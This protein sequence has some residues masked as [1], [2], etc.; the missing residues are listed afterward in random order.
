MMPR[1]LET[2]LFAKLI[3]ITL[4]N[5]FKNKKTTTNI[6]FPM[7]PI[8]YTIAREVNQKLLDGIPRNIVHTIYKLVTRSCI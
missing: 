3:D 8:F 5:Y 2:Y 6:S 1:K 7:K 4:F